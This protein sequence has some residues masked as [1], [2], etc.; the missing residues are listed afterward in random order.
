MTKTKP[1]SGDSIADMPRM[2][3][4][5]LGER[6]GHNASAAFSN[7]TFNGPSAI[8]GKLPRTPNKESVPPPLRFVGTPATNKHNGV[9]C[10]VF[11]TVSKDA[12]NAL[13]VDAPIPI[14]AS[15]IRDCPISRAPCIKDASICPRS[16]RANPP[17]KN[18]AICSNIFTRATCGTSRLTTNKT[19]LGLTIEHRN[20]S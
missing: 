2:A 11:F 8:L 5:P 6:K 13:R 20:T 16:I 1:Y 18:I 10:K 17:G 12:R 14:S 15:T 7:F 19:G 3:L 4:A 9:G